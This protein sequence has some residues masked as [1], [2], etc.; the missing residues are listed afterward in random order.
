MVRIS[1]K[2]LVKTLIKI[3]KFGIMRLGGVTVPHQL[4]KLTSPVTPDYRLVRRTYMF[5][6]HS[7]SI[8]IP[9]STEKVF[10]IP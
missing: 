3:A 6:K 2:K 10:S 7:I 9:P 4:R 5:S 1:D 8:Y